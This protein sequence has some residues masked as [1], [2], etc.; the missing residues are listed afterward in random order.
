[1]ADVN[2][3]HV[4]SVE[5]MGY[6]NSM[7]DDHAVY[8]DDLKSF[9]SAE[10]YDGHGG[11]K[12]AQIAAEMVTPHFLH[13]WSKES[14]KQRKDQL[15]TPD[16]L[17]NAYLAVDRYV[18]ESGFDSGTTAAGIYF[19]GDRFF[20][21]NCG[22]TRIVMG[23]EGGAI[24]LTVDHKPD[25]PA[26]QQRIEEKGG[27]VVCLGVARVQGILAVSRAIG[28]RSLKPF[29]VAEPRIVVGYVGRENDFVVVACDGVW[30]V[31][32]PE[33]AIAIA[34]AAE[35]AQAAAEN[36]RTSAIDSGSTDN[37]TVLVLDLRDYVAHLNRKK[38]EIVQVIDK[39]L[40]DGLE[41]TGETEANP[42]T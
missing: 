23:T 15:P 39:A 36:I 27:H 32:S 17:R 20:A 3:I 18:T 6:R 21:I 41:G 24:T 9:F 40:E 14:E 42:R 29:V 16:L 4:G 22:D 25:L 19:I 10:V 38:M 34:R 1:M 5:D 35:N 13:E 2:N 28:D 7:E 8:H 12:A 30:D 33:I 31:L 26:E 11:R 37:I